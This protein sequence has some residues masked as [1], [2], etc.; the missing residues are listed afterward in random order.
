M[1]L[2]SLGNEATVN[3][4]I[5][6][7]NFE[8]LLEKDEDQLGDKTLFIASPWKESLKTKAGQMV[9]RSQNPNVKSKG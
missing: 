1:V 6:W 2:A 9:V 5:C 4:S 8:K 7:K 3:F